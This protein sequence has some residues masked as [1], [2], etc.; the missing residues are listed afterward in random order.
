MQ[1]P[2]FWSNPPDAPGLAARLLAPAA[3]LWRWQAAR[4]IARPPRHRPQ[5]PV[6]CVGNLTVGGTGKTPVVSALLQRLGEKGIAAHALSR[7]YGG[8]EQGPLRVDP[9]LHG[10]AGVGDEPLLLSGFG[11]AWISRDRAAGARAAEAAGAAAVVLDDG[12]QNPDL[13]KD[14]AILVVDAVAGF[15]NGR[16]VPAGPL[17]EPVERGI[18]RA[19]LVIALGPEK[20]RERLLS[21]WPALGRLPVLG[22]TLA[23]LPTGMPWQGLRCLAFA[24]IGRPGKFFATLEALGADIVATR[25]FPDH[26]SYPRA[27]L[28]RLA[29]EADRLGA[30]LV[31]TEKDAVRLP[32]DF[33]H[34]VLTLP[35]RLSLGDWGPLDDALDRVLAPRK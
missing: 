23:P 27:I 5:V 10:A 28:Q 13:P 26:A 24:G 31:T 22:G 29:A 3:A 18:A 17:R 14:L 33:R 15:G 8:T 25:A 32:E 19:D 34:R 7:G 21:D 9:R 11:P 35:V 2:V 12:F 30:Q 1:A 4:R 16:V 20:A 6:I